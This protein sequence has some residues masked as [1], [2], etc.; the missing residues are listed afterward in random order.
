MVLRA[1]KHY[2]HHLLREQGLGFKRPKSLG[3]VQ[4]P[5]YGKSDLRD[6]SNFFSIEHSPFA[7]TTNTID[8]L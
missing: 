5:L 7:R 4:V 2:V 1:Y 6:S 3:I 8:Y